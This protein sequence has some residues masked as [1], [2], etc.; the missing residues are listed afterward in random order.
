VRAA[1]PSSKMSPAWP[2]TILFGHAGCDSKMAGKRASHKPKS[3][4]V[5]GHFPKHVPTRLR[6]GLYARDLRH[7]RGSCLVP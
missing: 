2:E 1:M 4:S 5:L 6:V 7:E 3:R